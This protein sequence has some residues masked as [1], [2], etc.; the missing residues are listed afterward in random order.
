MD[1][2]RNRMSLGRNCNWILTIHSYVVLHH[3]YIAISQCCTMPPK[4]ELPES[5]DIVIIGGGVIGTSTAWFLTSETELEV[6][7]LEKDQIGSGSTGD[8]SAIIRQFYGD[9]VLY[10]KMAWWSNKFYKNFEERTGE[11]IAY[12][13]NSLV[14][15]AS[16]GTEDAEIAE[17]G[18]KTLKSLDIPVERADRSR[19]DELYPML[20][21]EG[22]DFAVRD[23]E[24]AYSDGS[25]VAGG[26]AR[27][28]QRQG[29]N[30]I[31]GAQV[32]D[33]RTIDGVVQ[34][35]ETSEDQ[36]ACNDVII[37][38]GPWSSRLAGKI[39]VDVPIELS[40]EQ[41][42]ILD[43]PEEYKRKYISTIPSGR[44][45]ESSYK[46]PDFGDGVLIA[47][48]NQEGGANPDNYS[49]SPDES[50]LLELTDQL[51]QLV[52]ELADAGIKGQYCGIYS[53][54]PDRDF[55]IDTVGP[56][57]CYIACGFSGHGFKHGPAVGK[58]LTSMVVDGKTEIVDAEYFSLERFEDDPMGHGV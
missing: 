17:S 47:T 3:R 12:E 40:R 44:V 45:G 41:V 9:N 55:I 20:N 5:A 8:S 4:Q 53:N 52:P 18:Y 33:I 11:P 32:E 13:G 10:S 16:E 42:L 39:G 46:R 23:T 56:E 15:Y 57:G 28:A 54:T 27:S 29:A 22:I 26:F 36:I 38:A 2:P 30:I 37:A 58:M 7:L 6:V 14:A 48:H 43:P 51:E 19:M 21:S 35:V 49:D 31:L 1:R 50:V 24:A 25:D 34:A